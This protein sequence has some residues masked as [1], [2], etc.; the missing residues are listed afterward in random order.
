MLSIL[1]GDELERVP[2]H[3]AWIRLQPVARDDLPT[4]F[5][6]PLTPLLVPVPPSSVD[7]LATFSH[8]LVDNVYEG[9]STPR[10]WE[11]L[12]PSANTRGRQPPTR[13]FGTLLF[14]LFASLNY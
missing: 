10:T 14:Y 6:V 11:D 3:S 7:F 13:R 12:P 1:D 5:E 2:N 8:T 9:P 4:S